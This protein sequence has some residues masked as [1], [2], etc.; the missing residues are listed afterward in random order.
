LLKVPAKARSLDHFGADHFGAD[1]CSLNNLA[2]LGR[3]GR[4]RDAGWL[5]RIS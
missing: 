4:D 3:V 1:P 5:V 2:R